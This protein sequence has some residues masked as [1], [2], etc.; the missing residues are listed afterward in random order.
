MKFDLEQIMKYLINKRTIVLGI[1]GAIIVASL[2]TGFMYQKKM[3]KSAEAANM[4]DEAWQKIVFVGNQVQEK[5]NYTFLVNDPQRDQVKSLYKEGMETLDVLIS[6]Y[7]DTIAAARA[8]A[9]YLSIIDIPYLNVLLDDQELLERMKT[10]NYLDRVQK[11]HRKFW[12]VLI[13]LGQGTRKEQQGQH[14][15]AIALFKSALQ[16]DHEKYMNDYLLI[17]IARNYEIKNNYTEAI[18]YYQKVL[19][20]KNSVWSNFASAKIYILGQV[21]SNS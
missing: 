13:E 7:S 19:G 4:F 1:F 20:V 17:A 18:T 16:K 15:E 8:A 3:D 6:D 11:K 5:S 12:G 10:S 14:E 9:L 21:S 2:V